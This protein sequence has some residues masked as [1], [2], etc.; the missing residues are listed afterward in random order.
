M[1]RSREH[2]SVLSLSTITQY[3]PSLMCLIKP[4]PFGFLHRVSPLKA[5]L[6][7][8]ERLYSNAIRQGIKGTSIICIAHLF[9]LTALKDCNLKQTIDIT[10]LLFMEK[11]PPGFYY[12]NEK[13]GEESIHLHF[14]LAAA[15]CNRWVQIIG[16][17]VPC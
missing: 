8:A 10:M 4:G 12:C 13:L 9:P 11:N 15:L 1:H 3:F 7:L 14:T 2:L 6:Q 5:S 16:W 17:M